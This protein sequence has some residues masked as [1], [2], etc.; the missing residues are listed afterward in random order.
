[1][2][3]SLILAVASSL[4]AVE[5]IA[6]P[7]QIR[8]APAGTGSRFALISVRSASPVHLLGIKEVNS[9]PF[10]FSIGGDEG[11]Y[12]EVTLQND[13][14]LKTDDGKYVYSKP[15]NGEIGIAAHDN[16]VTKGFY[17]EKNELKNKNINF[18]A[19]PSGENKYSLTSSSWDG[20]LGIGLLYSKTSDN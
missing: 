18:Y 3:L 12:L 5:T 10:V 7:F 16:E 20:C 8:D 15:N 13:G 4:F 17:L 2:K 1:M 14:S 9:H 6:A 11:K 19:C